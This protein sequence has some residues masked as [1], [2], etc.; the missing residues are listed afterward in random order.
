VSTDKNAT[1]LEQLLEVRAGV[2]PRE[3]SEA[4]SLSMASVYRGIEDGSIPHKR[5]GRRVVIP[6]GALRDLMTTG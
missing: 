1:K 2:S 5:V 6:V 4:S 3:F